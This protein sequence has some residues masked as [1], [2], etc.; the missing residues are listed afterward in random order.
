MGWH[1]RCL[2]GRHGP[3]V[4]RFLCGYELVALLPRSPCPPI[5]HICRRWPALAW[6]LWFAFGHHL[7]IEEI[8]EVR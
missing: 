5:T 2:F 1:R 4:V 7:L 6:G 3:N 8:T